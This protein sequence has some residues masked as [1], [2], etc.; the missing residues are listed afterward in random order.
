LFFP[1]E[2]FM[3]CVKSGRFYNG[4]RH[5]VTKV[6]DFYNGGLWRN[7]FFFVGSIWNF[8]SGYIKNVDTHHESFSSQKQLIKK[9]SSKSLWQ[10]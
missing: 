3:V 10:T 5:D 9:L 6:G 2:T 4:G 7:F 1:V 8:V